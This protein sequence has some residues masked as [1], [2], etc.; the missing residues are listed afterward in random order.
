MLH[1]Q[2]SWYLSLLMSLHSTLL[3]LD[4][5]RST[6]LHPTTN[7]RTCRCPSQ[8]LFQTSHVAIARGA[9]TPLVYSMDVEFAFFG[10]ASFTVV[11][12]VKDLPCSGP[13]KYLL[14]STFSVV[15]TALKKELF[16]CDLICAVSSVR[17]SPLWRS[18]VTHCPYGQ[19][20]VISQLDGAKN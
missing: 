3:V 1:A 4:R 12:S 17:G 8:S 14:A 9:I 6:H 20:R 16:A 13:L 10:Y 7:S 15:F 5:S 2:R 19:L 11:F 18:L